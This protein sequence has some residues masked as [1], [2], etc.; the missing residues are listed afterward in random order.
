[1]GVVGIRSWESSEFHTRKLLHLKSRHTTD[2]HYK[3][4]ISISL[5]QTDVPNRHLIE[6]Q[7]SSEYLK[8]E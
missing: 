2:V 5:A 1:M 6:D 8:K 7:E 3:I 4:Q